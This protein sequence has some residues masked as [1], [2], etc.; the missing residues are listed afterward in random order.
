MKR[1][2]SSQN[3][4]EQSG[5]QKTNGWWCKIV[6]ADVDHD[7]DMDLIMGNM[8]TNTQFKTTVDQPLIT[9]ADDFDNNGRI[10]PLMTWYIQ[11]VSYP[12]NSRDEMTGQMPILK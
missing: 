10:D 2:T 12:F 7:G 4:S 1:E 3:I 11:N 5:L 8:G 9:Y 6:P